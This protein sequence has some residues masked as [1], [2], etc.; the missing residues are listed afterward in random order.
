MPIS[1]I[2][3]PSGKILQVGDILISSH[4]D[5]T[6][7]FARVTSVNSTNAGVEFVGKFQTFQTGDHIISDQVAYNSPMSFY[8]LFDPSNPDSV[9][10]GIV[11][12]KISLDND[13][14][15]SV[16]VGGRN[17]NIVNP[18]YFKIEGV[19]DQFFVTD[20]STGTMYRSTEDMI[21]IASTSL[22]DNSDAI[23]IFGGSMGVIHGVY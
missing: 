14:Q 4:A 2:T 20:L 12:V 9:G 21:K 18:I 7:S 15:P 10:S 6:G 3:V 16:G 17:Y 22:P 11:L 23:W 1:Q 13:S 19:N 5:S 8:K